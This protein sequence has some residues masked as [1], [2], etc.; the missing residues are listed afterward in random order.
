M[1]LP[2]LRSGEDVSEF[3]IGDFYDLRLARVGGVIF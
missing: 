3:M 1:S 2:L